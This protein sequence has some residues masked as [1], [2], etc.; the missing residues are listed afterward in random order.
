[1]FEPRDLNHGTLIE[2]VAA[3]SGTDPKVV[4][5]VLRTFY[6]VIGRTVAKGFKVAV[7]NF[8]TWYR[9]EVAPR[10][11]R[12]PSTGEEYLSKRANYPRFR[13]APR[14]RQAV[15]SG[16]DLTTLQKRGH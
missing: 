11:M 4:E 3:Q 16:E 14:F 13:V 6:D 2:V 5:K 9:S 12:D 15:V 7:T 1:M 10:M 8:G